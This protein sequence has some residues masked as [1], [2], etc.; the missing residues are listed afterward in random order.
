LHYNDFCFLQQPFA[1]YC[2]PAHFDRKTDLK[3]EHF[4]PA[5][6]SQGIRVRN[7]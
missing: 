4:N 2:R 5:C 3:E 1:L 6:F 7:G